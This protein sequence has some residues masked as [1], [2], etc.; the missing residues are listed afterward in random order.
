MLS[1]IHFGNNEIQTVKELRVANNNGQV[2]ARIF[3]DDEGN[4]TLVL[5]SADN[6]PSI[7]LAANPVLGPRVYLFDPNRSNRNSGYVLAE[8]G[9]RLPIKD[10]TNDAKGYLTL[11]D[12]KGAN[13]YDSLFD[14]KQSRRIAP[15]DSKL[16]EHLYSRL[17]FQG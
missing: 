17:H 15:L 2:G 11:Y 16:D 1:A 7:A 14:D 9:T 13:M 3:T 6:T 12:S 8:L 4:G 5:N 10:I